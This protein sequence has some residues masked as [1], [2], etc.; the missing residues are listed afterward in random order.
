MRCPL[1]LQGIYT[2][3][4]RV[5]AD[6]KYT[7]KQIRSFRLLPSSERSRAGWGGVKDSRKSRC[8]WGESASGGRGAGGVKQKEQLYWLVSFSVSPNCRPSC[9]I[10]PLPPPPPPAHWGWKLG[11]CVSWTTHLPPHR[12]VGEGRQAHMLPLRGK[13]NAWALANAGLG[14]ACAA[15]QFPCRSP[16]LLGS[17]AHRQRFPD[18][19]WSPDDQL[20]L[21]I[22]EQP[23]P[24]NPFIRRIESSE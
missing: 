11:N 10:P 7:G 14:L 21:Q 4:C 5:M 17:C 12:D 24:S 16:H 23:S 15:A 13:G 6:G 8:G 1:S 19:P 18:A 22:S 20:W 2:H 9:P 3:A